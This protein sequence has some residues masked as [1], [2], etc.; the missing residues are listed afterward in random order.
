MEWVLQKLKEKSDVELMVSWG[1][2][3]QGESLGGHAAF[4]TEIIQLSDGSFIVKFMDDARQG[5]DT[6]YND[7]HT[8][9]FDKEGN[10]LNGLGEGGR[11][12][13]F[14]VETAVPEPG[15]LLLFCFGLIALCKCFGIWRPVR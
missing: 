2:N 4:V 10:L 15:T 11:L 13:G 5:D 6:A 8:L 12:I 1:K 14:Q 9:W 3:E 7:M